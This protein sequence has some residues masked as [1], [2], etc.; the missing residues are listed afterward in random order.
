MRRLPLG[1]IE[2]FVVVARSG[3]L[4]RAAQIMNLTVPALSRRIQQLEAYL[5]LTLFRRL[6]RGLGLTEAGAAYFSALAPAWDGVRSATE[7]ARMLRALNDRRVFS[8]RGDAAERDEQHG[9]RG[10]F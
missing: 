9:G 10:K 4:A 1:S 3:S 5:G 6:P 8:P 7:G 2:A